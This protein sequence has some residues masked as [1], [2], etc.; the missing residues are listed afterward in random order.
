MKPCTHPFLLAVF[1]CIPCALY[2]EESSPAY[3]VIIDTLT[4]KR[5]DVEEFIGHSPSHLAFISEMEKIT[6]ALK[7]IYDEELDGNILYRFII[8]KLDSVKNI[9]IDTQ[10]LIGDSAV[11]AMCATDL[12]GILDTASLDNPTGRVTRLIHQIDFEKTNTV[13]RKFNAEVFLVI[14]VICTIIVSGIV[15]VF[16]GRLPGSL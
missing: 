15:I 11:K 4:E 1:A 14:G 2:A 7:G 3:P 9:T 5:I 12:H 13:K 10:R 6:V 8:D 16:Y